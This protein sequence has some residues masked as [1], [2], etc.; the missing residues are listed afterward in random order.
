MIL[1]AL[2]I[3]L[4]TVP[5]F[6]VMP[7]LP[8]L[9]VDETE[10]AHQSDGS[11]ATRHECQSGDHRPARESGEAAD[12]V[13]ARATGTEPRPE[14]DKQPGND[15]LRSRSCEARRSLAGDQ[16]DEQC[17][18][19][20]PESEG[21]RYGARR[22]HIGNSRRTGEHAAHTCDTAKAEQH[23]QRIGVQHA[24]LEALRADRASVQRERRRSLPRRC[25]YRGNPGG[26]GRLS[27]ALS[28]SP[29]HD[30]A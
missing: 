6:L 7:S 16:R 13:P 24:R 3:L 14:T 19:R 2:R 17:S 20:K 30:T 10:C 18:Q 11:K 22:A 21:E 27:D 26:L 28:L 25:R 15:Q 29:T 4:L 1:P 5:M 12:P 23:D 9:S 8:R